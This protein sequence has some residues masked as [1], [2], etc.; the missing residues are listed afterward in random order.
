MNFDTRTVATI[1]GIGLGSGLAYVLSRKRKSR[2]R[3]WTGNWKPASRFLAGVAGGAL[4]YY[5]MRRPGLLGKTMAT[6]GMGLI[7]RG[8]TNRA[9]RSV[10]GMAPI[11]AGLRR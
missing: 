3:P 2:N 11:L 9:T 5:G 8:A 10:F 7:T 4:S 1:G 6:A